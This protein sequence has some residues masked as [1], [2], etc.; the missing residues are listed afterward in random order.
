[1]LIYC[2]LLFKCL[3]EVGLELKVDDECVFKEVVLF[4]DCLDVIEEFI[5]LKSYLE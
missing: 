3:C 2:E 5:W 4:V 1:M